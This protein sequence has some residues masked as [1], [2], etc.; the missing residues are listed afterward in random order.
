MLHK[1]EEIS[2]QQKDEKREH[3]NSHNF[4]M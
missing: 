1:K 2:A 4:I 3:I